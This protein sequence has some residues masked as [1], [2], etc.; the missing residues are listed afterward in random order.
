M[1]DK[2]T[3]RPGIGIGDLKFG[4]SI[5]E[6]EAYFGSADTR[7]QSK[8]GNDST[9]RLTWGDDVTCWFDS[10]DG[11]RLGSILVEHTNALLS[12]HKLIGRPRDEIIPLLSPSFGEPEF[13]DM[14]VM[15]LPDNWLATYDAHSLNLWFEYGRLS[16]IQWGYLFDDSGDN[17]IWPT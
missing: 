14:S 10:D 13:E 7:E 17:A 6:A 2:S 15:E 5:G 9:L 11:F 16:S 8:L 12:G 4:A 3:V 1:A